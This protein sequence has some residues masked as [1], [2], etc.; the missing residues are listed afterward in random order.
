MFDFLYQQISEEKPNN[1][2][3]S[4]SLLCVLN[5][6]K[7]DFG[8]ARA[9]SESKA[10]ELIKT[11]IQKSEKNIKLVRKERVYLCWSFRIDLFLLAVK[12][13][14]LQ[15]ANDLRVD[16]EQF[17]DWLGTSVEQQVRYPWHPHL[18]VQ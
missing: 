2:L 3:V 1:S 8:L 16:G 9:I 6:S 4:A 18:H 13:S 5:M 12:E 7:S 14:V 10:I 15:S 11:I 17:V